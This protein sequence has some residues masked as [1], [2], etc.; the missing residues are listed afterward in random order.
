MFFFKQS[1][2]DY[3]NSVTKVKMPVSQA[4]SDL[5]KGL[6]NVLE[7]EERKNLSEQLL[8]ELCDLAG[9]DIV[10]FNLVDSNQIHRQRAG[11]IV[12]KRY[13]VYQVNSKTITIHHR[14]AGRGQIFA[15]KSYLDTLLHEWLHHYDFKKLKLNSIHSR[16]FYLRL[17]D[18]K[19]K[20]QIPIQKK[21]R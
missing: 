15:A 20:L 17:N 14:T 6:L 18:L 21:S 16:G 7:Y 2:Y 4:A 11:R 10:E 3:S 5:A 1:N 12:M 13:G 8:D 19:A 9:V